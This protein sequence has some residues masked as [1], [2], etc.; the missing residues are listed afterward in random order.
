MFEEKSNINLSEQEIKKIL[1]K[2][3][4]PFIQTKEG[5]VFNVEEELIPQRILDAL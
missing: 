5:H 3:E 2:S 1:S 4:S